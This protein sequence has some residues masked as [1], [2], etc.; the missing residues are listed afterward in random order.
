MSTNATGQKWNVTGTV[1]NLKQKPMF[2][3]LQYEH[4]GTL[5]WPQKKTTSINKATKSQIS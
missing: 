5:E 4:L 3:S 2:L 1:S